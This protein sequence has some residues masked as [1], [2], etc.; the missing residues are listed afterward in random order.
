MSFRVAADI[1][2][3]FTDIAL[4][5][6]DGSYATCKVPS[7]P[8]VFEQAIIQGIRQLMETLRVP[9]SDL[10]EILH[11]CT[12]GTNAIL[13][14]KGARTAFVTTSGFRDLLE[15]RRIRVPR[16]YDPLYVKPVPLVP[17]DLAFEVVERMGFDGQVIVPLDADS[18]SRLT[19]MLRQQDVEAIAVCLLNSYANPE[20]ERI[21]GDRLRT[22]FPDCFI[23]LSSD[24]L[25]EIRE[26]ERAS[27]TVVNAYVGPPVTRYL[28]SLINE[29]GRNGISAPLRIMQSSGG[30]LD[31]SS[32]LSRPAQL[33][34]C[35]PAAGVMA[36]AHISRLS[37]FGKIIT[38]DMGGTT[39][40]AAIVE[41]G[42][43]QIADE[44]EVGGGISLSSRLVKGS[45]YPLKLPAIDISEVGAGGGSIVWLDKAGAIK[46]GPKS[47]GA[48][49][50]PACYAAGNEEPTVT[51]ANVVLG[52]L[53]PDA[54]AGGSVPISSYLSRKAI[55]SRIADPLKQ[56]VV[57]AAFGI[58]SVANSNM[59]RAV[60]SVTTYK[61]R[62]PREFSMMAFG[63]NGGIH[64]VE[65]ARA[66]RIKSV[67]IPAAAGVF[68]ALGLMFVDTELTLT[69]GLVES[70]DRIDA[71][72]VQAGFEKLQTRCA[73]EMGHAE[74]DLTFKRYL[75]M[76]YV[77]QA[78]ELIV[79]LDGKSFNLE[80]MAKAERDF[81]KAH[82]QQHGFRTIGVAKFQ[83]VNLRV[84]G[85]KP[86]SNARDRFR[87]ISSNPPQK[88]SASRARPVYFGPSFGS[89]STPILQR[90]DLGT[91][92]I[93]GPVI[94]EEYEGTIVVPPDCSVK[95][96]AIG[97][98][99]I[100][101]GET[102]E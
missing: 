92:W 14:H 90:W 85:K 3:T 51:D 19:D 58:H 46:V 26:Y 86:A 69:K 21:V 55:E 66:L 47:A 59:V 2:G 75:D 22:A 24:I 96:D 60:K 70:S 62:D 72:M 35:G 93:Q 71:S 10:E 41:N 81:E 54:L 79:E 61:G 20:H 12:V 15:L 5:S 28:A 25:P 44:Y 101:V 38:F 17:R 63:G 73:A 78:F 65:L 52:F 1:G 88:R 83:V 64:A 68:S 30:I 99:L 39:A 40:K 29:L 97:N 45:G 6:K 98:V 8:P 18:V 33:I 67:I 91:T 74:H 42:Q 87:G 32:V 11:A 53:N 76:R 57:E 16:L 50:G 56:G 89:Q 102:D 77:G 36:A 49:P 43:F 4:L 37:G 23:T 94:V 48:I 80:A 13:E 27:T 31:S 34:E 7:T 100:H 82:Q 84:I 95:I 9:L